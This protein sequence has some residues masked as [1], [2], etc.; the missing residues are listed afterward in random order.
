[1]TDT[2][3][4]HIGP[5]QLNLRAEDLGPLRYSAPGHREFFTAGHF[6]REPEPLVT[7]EV[8]ID[9]RI[10]RLPGS[11][12]L[13]R[14]GQSWAAWDAGADLLCCSGFQVPGRA[15]FGCRVAR[16]LSRADLALD[17]EWADTHED[18]RESPLR[19]PLDQVLA[20]G[21]LARIGG[22][23]LHAAVAVHAGRGWVFAG[24][25]GA[26]KSTMSGLCRAAGWRVLNDDRVM[27]FRRAGE[28]R[29][30]GTPWHGTGAFAE[31]AEVPLGGIFLLRQARDERLEPLPVSQARLALLD[32]AAVPWF[33]DTWSQQT[34]DGL[35]RLAEDIA[36]CRFHFTKT[37]TAVAAL[38]AGLD[39]RLEVYA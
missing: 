30:A 6:Q 24:R 4:L 23:L 10:T 29:V 25:S 5:L 21:M 8:E 32:V 34:L 22:A 9:K 20:W 18:G 27:V 35:N 1:M 16:D 19:F 17:P 38:A 26:G 11:E 14:G 39:R 7:A 37:G 36:P 13:W 31:A 33:E 12:P 3:Q 28:W 15:R 2:G